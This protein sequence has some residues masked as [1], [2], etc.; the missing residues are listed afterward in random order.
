MI[1]LEC[2][3]ELV[4]LFYAD[5]II[6]GHVDLSINESRIAPQKS[7]IRD[8]DLRLAMV[9]ARTKRV[10]SHFGN[11]IAPRWYDLPIAVISIPRFIVL[12]RALYS[13]IVLKE[14][15]HFFVNF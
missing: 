5:T 3:Q 10:K 9:R 8:C 6:Y 12:R 14:E 15:R 7:V 11:E 1:S 13:Y 2:S 4:N